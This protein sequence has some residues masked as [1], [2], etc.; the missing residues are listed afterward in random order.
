VQTGLSYW[1]TVG[2]IQEHGYRISAL[3]EIVWLAGG[4]ER[5]ALA[6]ELF[7][8]L[9]RNPKTLWEWTRICLRAP[10]A[11]R[12]FRSYEEV[13]RGDRFYR[14]DCYL[15][16][17]RIAEGVLLP[18][19]NGRVVV[20]WDE[21]L[22]LPRRT[23]ESLGPGHAAHFHFDVNECEVAVLLCKGCY[24]EETEPCLD[25]VAV[26][27]RSQNAGYGACRLFGPKRQKS[28]S[29]RV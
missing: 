25:L 5:I 8:D 21:R 19:G 18:E 3:E 14:A 11:G 17:Q 1:R 15:D 26:F 29:V 12:S 6:D 20:E 4:N 16:E 22:F 13:V 7:T 9:L 2:F 10:R 24:A 23:S 27:R 28:E